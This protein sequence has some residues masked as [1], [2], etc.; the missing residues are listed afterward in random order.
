MGAILTG[1]TTWGVPNLPKGGT[2]PVDESVLGQVQA[3]IQNRDSLQ[4][5]AAEANSALEKIAA[6]VTQAVG[7]TPIVGPPAAA[8]IELVEQ[9]LK[10]ARR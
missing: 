5:A 4:S 7:A 9:F 1:L 10:S 3:V 8:A 6:G 2:T